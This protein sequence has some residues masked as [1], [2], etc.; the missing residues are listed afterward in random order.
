MQKHLGNHIGNSLLMNLS[1]LIKLRTE[2]NLFT[3]LDSLFLVLSFNLS[4][5]VVIFLDAEVHIHIPHVNTK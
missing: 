5:Q 1:F 2:H 3:S 4:S